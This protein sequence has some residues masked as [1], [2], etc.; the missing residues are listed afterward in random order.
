[1]RIDKAK[2]GSESQSL[3]PATYHES[4]RAKHCLSVRCKVQGIKVSVELEQ[5]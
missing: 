4:L 5:V 2:L 3:W 1:L